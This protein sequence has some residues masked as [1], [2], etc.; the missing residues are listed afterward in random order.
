MQGNN[1]CKSCGGALSPSDRFCPAC[2]SGQ[3]AGS[4]G[5]AETV[6]SQGS[7]E[8]IITDRL[9]EAT[10]G[11]FDILERIGYGSMGSVYLAR[12]VALSRRVAIKVISPQLLQDESMVARFRLEAQTVAALRHP[13]IVNVYAVREI[14][15]LH[16]FIMD[17]IDGPSLRSLI[18]AHGPL[19]VG[20]TQALL[21][22]IG[23]ALS[24]AHR[25]GRGVIHRD[26]KPANVMID[27]EGT[28][29]VMDFG[30]SKVGASRSGLTQTGATIGTPEYMSPEQCM[31]KELT[32]ASDQYALGIV[33][34]EML[35]GA[36]PFK[37]STYAIMM[38]HAEGTPPSIRGQRPDCPPEVEATVMRML[39]K[40]A[41]ERFADLE[42]AMAAMGG[43][44]LGHGDPVRDAIVALVESVSSEAAGLDESSP[45]SPVPPSREPA[46]IA[47]T[48]LPDMVQLG[49]TFDLEAE[50]RRTPGAPID[51]SEISWTTSDPSI[52]TVEG[53]T[54]STH[55]IGSA[56]LTAATGAVAD[57][58]LL[59]VVPAPA[60][61]VSIRPRSLTMPAGGTTPIQAVVLDRNGNALD[62][63][64]RWYSEN[65]EGAAV[66]PEG[67][68]TGISVGTARIVAEADGVSGSAQ[69]EV[70]EPSAAVATPPHD[71]TGAPEEPK[72]RGRAWLGIAALIVV[73]LGLSQVFRSSGTPK[74][75]DVVTVSLPAIADSLTVGDT[76]RLAPTVHSPGGPTQPAAAATH[77]MSSHA[78]VAT[79]DDAGLVLA[80]AGGL[81]TISVR[82]GDVTASTE[83]MVM[84][85]DHA[86]TGP[87]LESPVSAQDAPRP[88]VVASPRRPVVTSVE[89]AVRDP[90]LRVGG[91]TPISATALTD[92]GAT[93]DDAPVEWH[94]S[95]SDVATIRG[96][97]L[98]AAGPGTT[99]ITATVAGVVGRVGVRV[100]ALP[101]RQEVAAL[102]QE[103]FVDLLGRRDT[104]AVERLFGRGRPTPRQR[105]I[106]QRMRE[107]SFAAQI[108]RLDDV[109]PSGPG[110][111]MDFELGLSW[112]DERGARVPSTAA[113]FQARLVPTATGWRL[114][115]VERLRR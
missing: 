96:D 57:T 34:Y 31:D 38:G 59:T 39:A 4:G 62:R 88:E 28:P 41:D 95:A 106:I 30:I 49:D 94:S 3:G 36:V 1:S 81:T 98:V 87:E 45:L 65:D 29:V 37:G 52:A 103:R 50:S 86:E 51:A 10:T 61:E 108:T 8:R 11:E 60:A 104:R 58:I 26:V 48:G 74:V 42:E 80:L 24:Y 67:V 110:V 56:S 85:S 20:V 102:L 84:A 7:L 16:F 97:Q 115:G 17:F 77:W 2:G 35:T 19:D 75:T 83:L 93:L 25:R 107:P 14:A 70:E 78:D 111:T 13:N 22:Q 79:V 105:E 32:G 64:V 43:R 53:G 82:V 55:A 15:D 40:S 12:D 101:S 6:P 100:M 33:A 92:G 5:S 46:P 44:P 47:I 99:M 18:K 9:T 90:L 66:S 72:G 76:L 89:I 114:A 68:V 69:I 73:V 54:V 109:T 113:S 112:R 23:S 63:P 71:A 21:F 91:R 27:R